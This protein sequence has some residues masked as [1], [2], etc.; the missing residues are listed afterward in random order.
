[1]GEGGRHRGRG[2]EAQGVGEGG[3]GGGGGRHRGWGSEA[4]GVGEGGTEL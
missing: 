3:T 2:R 1:M 4:Q